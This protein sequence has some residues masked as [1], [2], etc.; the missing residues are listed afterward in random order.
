MRAQKRAFRIE[1][2]SQPET[3]PHPKGASAHGGHHEILSEIKQLRALIRPPEEVSKQMIDAYRAEMQEAIKLK[4]ELDQIWQAIDQTKHEIA[5][6]H[7]TGF[8]GK[9]MTRVTHELDAIVTGT[10]QA[11]EG[12]L[13]AAEGI[14]Q[15]ASQLAAKLK[16]TQDKAA[17][18]DIQQKI[19]TVFEHCNFQDLTGQR[20]TKVVNTLKFIEDR[21]VK[22]MEIWGGL[23]SFKDIEVEGIAEATGDAALL[24]GPKLSEDAGHASQDD[25]DAL[26][27]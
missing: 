4:A 10:E 7:V 20:I 21:I 1:V 8:K 19:I 22:M 24:N 25:I 17:I 15:I 11:T 16:S 23:D 5:T 3:S 26:F 14:D 9:Q 18:D 12:I 27:N 13:S 6:L 2:I